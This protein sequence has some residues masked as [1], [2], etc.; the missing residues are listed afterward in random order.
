[1]RTDYFDDLLPDSVTTV[2]RQK[3][4]LVTPENRKPAS[5]N[6]G[7]DEALPVLPLLPVKTSNTEDD[8][9]SPELHGLTL[10]ELEAEAADDW[11]E[12]QHNPGQL[13]AF[14]HAVQTRHMRESG[15]RPLHYTQRAECAHC[16]PV[17]LWEGA[18][19]N[20]SGCP[21]CF[22]RATDVRIPRPPRIEE[23]IGK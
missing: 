4:G 12:I 19:D 16:G 17:W 7:L 23:C 2:T 20:V 14:A 22:N 18:P 3:P 8:S 6:S 5:K 21:W 9:Y 11:Q 13:E 1:M 10:A 15:L